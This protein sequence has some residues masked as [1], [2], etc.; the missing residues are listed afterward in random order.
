MQN[1]IEGLELSSSKFYN[2]ILMRI[3]M[4][5]T[6]WI[7]CYLRLQCYRLSS[8]QSGLLFS[9]MEDERKRNDNVALK[10]GL[11]TIP[12]LISKMPKV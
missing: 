7:T 12:M 9:I 2:F 5:E 4:L 11:A 10:E 1:I 3:S 6:D 8:S